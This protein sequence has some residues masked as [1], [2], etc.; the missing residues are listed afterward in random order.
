MASDHFTYF[1]I[2]CYSLWSPLEKMFHVHKY[3]RSLFLAK[4]TCTSFIMRLHLGKLLNLFTAFCMFD[5]IRTLEGCSYEDWHW[6]ENLKCNTI[7]I[8]EILINM[9][10]ISAY[11]TIL[12]RVIFR[13]V[14]NI[15]FIMI[16]YF[17]FL[18]DCLLQFQF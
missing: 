13:K 5:Y 10:F 16:L 7:F 14:R 18:L 1:R 8:C 6:N 3:I 17:F 12:K 2:A 15:S 11:L 4:N 9:I